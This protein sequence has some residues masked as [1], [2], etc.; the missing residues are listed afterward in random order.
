[1]KVKKIINKCHDY[2]NIRVLNSVGKLI[3]QGYV[4]DLKRGYPFDME[5]Y[6][7]L[8]SK[9]LGLRPTKMK[10]N[11][12]EKMNCTEQIVLDI[13]IKKGDKK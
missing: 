4:L 8:N 6:I 7:I 10:M 1:M 2:E 12:N 13:Y 3:W 5:S 11:Y 9:V